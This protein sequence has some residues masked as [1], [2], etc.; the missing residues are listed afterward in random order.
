M[1]ADGKER[2]PESTRQMLERRANIVRSRLL[3]TVDAL[4]SRR[5]QVENIGD[6]AKKLA[7]P[8]AA[9]FLGVAVVAFGTVM[10]I[11]SVFKRR[12]ERLLSVRIGHALDRWRAP[13][14][15][16]VFEEVSRKA[17]AT[18]VTMVAT[19]VARRTLKNVIDGRL[20]DGRVA[21]G[22]ALEAHHQ[23]LAR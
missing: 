1:S 8:V 10:G 23:E 20:P 7:M 21:V 19:E 2:S 4:D 12:H 15:Q 17:L 3:R 22:Q 14:R 13:K 5:H 6:Q 9:T 16:S 11:R 18:V